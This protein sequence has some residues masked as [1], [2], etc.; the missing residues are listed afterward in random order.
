MVVTYRHG[1]FWFFGCLFVPL[2]DCLFVILYFKAA[3][4]SFF[5]SL[6]GLTA[7]VLAAWMA[8]IQS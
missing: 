5:L 4:K 6:L 1:P 2:A 3:R 8:G 7:C